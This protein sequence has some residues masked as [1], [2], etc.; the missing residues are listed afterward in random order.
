MG[1]RGVWLQAQ[2]AGLVLSSIV[3]IVV[4]GLSLTTAATFLVAGAVWV[5][6]R[7]TRAGLWW[8]FG[9][10]PATPFERERVQAAIVQIVWSRGRHQPTIWV[11]R[12]TGED[13]AIMPTR[14]DLVVSI[15]LLG[16]MAAGRLAD[17][18]V[19]AVVSLAS[20]RQPVT[21]SALVASMDAYCVPWHIV[22]IL[23]SA[24]RESVI[25][26]PLL[27]LAWRARWI[28]F[29]MAMIDNWYARRWSGLISV[30]LLALVSGLAPRARRRWQ[31]ALWNLG[32]ERV[33][34]DGFDP[35]R[36]SMSRA[37]GRTLP[38]R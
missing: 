32:L 25:Q 38:T 15:G 9:A 13:D 22:T 26:T 23:T 18:Q 28:V 24:I 2:I 14:R 7:N 17:E 6:S 1:W 12:R 35:A 31:I 37:T 29:G 36:L 4:A 20:G 8:R 33:M 19:C 16:R 11:G 3:W 34:S 5:L 30:A 10:R 21:G 27:S